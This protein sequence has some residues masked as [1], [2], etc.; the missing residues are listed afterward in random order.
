LPKEEG[1]A[2]LPFDYFGRDGFRLPTPAEWEEACRAGST[3]KRFFGE[4]ETLAEAFAWLNVNGQGVLQPVGQL[5]PNRAGLFDVY[6]NAIDVTLFFP[7]ER[8]PSQLF[9]KGLSAGALG[10]RIN[11]YMFGGSTFVPSQ[12]AIS[13]PAQPI[14]IVLN[15][16]VNE[17]TV[18]LRVVRRIENVQ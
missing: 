4:D 17:T 5:L 3:T 6:G 1:T 8:A 12:Y 7:K 15:H 18:G 14:L 10:N 2:Q 13:T 11:T 9:P 16:G